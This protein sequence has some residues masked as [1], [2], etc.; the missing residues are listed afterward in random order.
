M[1]CL[2][3]VL[4]F[5]SKCQSQEHRLCQP[6]MMTKSMPLIS[7]IN[8]KYLVAECSAAK[9]VKIIEPSEEVKIFNSSVY[10]CP[11]KLERSSL[12]SSS[13]YRT[14]TSMPPRLIIPYK[15]K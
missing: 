12:R 3:K 9:D 2:D 4:S 8:G 5:K 1:E 10:G 11:A 14:L 7:G 15:A 13:L 6:L